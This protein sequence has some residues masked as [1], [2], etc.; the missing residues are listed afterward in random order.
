MHWVISQW[1][2][3]SRSQPLRRRSS[4]AT[5]RSDARPPTRLRLSP[6]R[7]LPTACI[8]RPPDLFVSRQFCVFA[9]GFIIDYVHLSPAEG[10]PDARIVG[11]KYGALVIFLGFRDDQDL[12]GV[13]R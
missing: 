8:S 10:F 1:S 5:M 7:P 13:V 6:A 4:T 11:E 3:Q 9:L 2:Q 12:V